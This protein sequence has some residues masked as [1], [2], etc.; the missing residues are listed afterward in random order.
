MDLG[1]LTFYLWMT[2]FYSVELKNLNVKLF[3][4]YWQFMKK[5][6]DRKSIETRQTFFFFNSNTHLDV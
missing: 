4:I 1:F 2:V 5:D 3:L 6:S